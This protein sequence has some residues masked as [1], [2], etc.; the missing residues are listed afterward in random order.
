MTMLTPD[1][2]S[3]PETLTS[4]EVAGPLTPPSVTQRDAPTFRFVAVEPEGFGTCQVE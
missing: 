4:S 3:R 1:F 2:S